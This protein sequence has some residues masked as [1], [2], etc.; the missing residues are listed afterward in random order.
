M[1]FFRRAKWRLCAN[2]HEYL[3]RV[4]EENVQREL[5]K[6]LEALEKDLPQSRINTRHKPR[7]DNARIEG[8]EWPNATMEK[9]EPLEW[10]K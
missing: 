2:L 10:D 4:L 3:G 8:R 7:G 1:N 6:T 9:P 5:Q